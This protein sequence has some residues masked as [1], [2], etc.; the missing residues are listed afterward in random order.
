MNAYLC[1][2]RRVEPNLR[3]RRRT[4][5]DAA[6]DPF[7]RAFLK[8]Y[9]ESY[10]DWGDDPS[11][12][13]AR[14][15]LGDVNRAS[16]GVCRRDVRLKLQKDDIV[17]FFCGRQASHEWRYYFVG[18]GTVGASIRR[19]ELWTDPSYEP[20]RRFYNVLARFD[21]KHLVQSETFHPYH[22]NWADRAQ[23]PY[24]IF[25]VARSSFNI[26][27]PHHVATWNGGALPE[28]WTSDLRS[29]EI[30]RLL[31]TEREIFHRRLR[32]SPTGYGHPKLNLVLNGHQTRPGR[33]LS[34]LTLALRD[35]V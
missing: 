24:V 7:L 31:F 3:S 28:E 12:F 22:E 1:T 25:D 34:D 23:A 16:W 9:D 8:D 26:T 32:T 10:Y 6:Q 4:E 33:G 20:Y 11:F 35:L 18:F 2:Y 29:N 17:V 30:E 13:S 15:F 19:E 21:G 14:S 5:A 27:S